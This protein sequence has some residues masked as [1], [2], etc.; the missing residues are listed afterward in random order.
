MNSV[1]YLFDKLDERSKDFLRI[2]VERI[3]DQWEHETEAKN[4]FI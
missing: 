4:D 1:F 3:E 2:K